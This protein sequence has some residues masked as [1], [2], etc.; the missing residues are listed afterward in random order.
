MRKLGGRLEPNILASVEP[1]EAPLN[2]FHTRLFHGGGALPLLSSKSINTRRFAKMK[3]FIVYRNT[4]D[5]WQSLAFG[6]ASIR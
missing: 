4:R 6:K 3:L 1:N 5:L 2:I